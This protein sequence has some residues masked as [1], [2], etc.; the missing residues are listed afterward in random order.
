[1]I[2]MSCIDVYFIGA[3]VQIET[4][5]E[6]LEPVGSIVN[7]QRN[8]IPLSVNAVV[9]DKYSA[10]GLNP[11]GPEVTR[12]FVEPMFTVPIEKASTPVEISKNGSSKT[13]IDHD[14]NEKGGIYSLTSLVPLQPISF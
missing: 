9:P 13:Q 3:A 2:I 7:S 12:S 14:V 10:I 6:Q 8:N 11:V 5:G 4:Q 1:M